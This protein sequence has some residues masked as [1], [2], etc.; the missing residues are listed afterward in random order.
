MLTRGGVL[1]AVLGG[2]N[3]AVDVTTV[4]N[5]SWMILY[6][7]A[8][9]A[10][11]TVV[12]APAGWTP[13]LASALQQTSG[14]RSAAYFAKIKEASDGVV[15]I[16]TTVAAAKRAVVIWGSGSKPVS[17]WNMGLVGVRNATH[18]VSGQ[19]IQAGTGFTSVAPAVAIDEADSLA[20]AILMEATA[21]DSSFALTSGG[22]LW[23]TW[24]DESAYIEQVL[25]AYRE[26]ATPGPGE[27]FVATSDQVQASN[28]QAMQVVIP[29]ETD[30][31]PELPGLPVETVAGPAR[32]TYLNALGERVTPERVRLLRPGFESVD[33]MLATPGATWA[34]R[35]GSLGYAE[36]SE[37]AYDQS[38]IRGY[39][40]LEFSAQR[41]SDGWW[42]GLHDPTLA[43]TSENVA[44][45]AAVNTMT[46]AQVESYFN[47]LNA[48][49]TPRPYFD[50]IEFLDKWSPSRVLILD[51]K[52]ALA[53]NT[54]FLDILD[55]HGGPE[56]IV[57]K[58]WGPSSTAIPHAVAARNRGYE[59]WGYFYEVDRSIA[60]GGNGQLD[61][62]Q[63]HWTILGMTYSSP[64]ATWDE[65]LAFDKPTVAHIAPDQSAY[66]L[67][68]SKGADMVQ[69]SG[70]NAI[71]PVGP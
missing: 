47:T 62:F 58:W 19:S 45:T 50:M 64:Q 33:Q 23:T 8:S 31:E 59:T 46:R 67:A 17:E 51:P 15:T 10:S 60:L 44:L 71:T 3:V 69:C 5:G 57:W 18:A 13:L 32:L 49:S 35:G 37:F 11:A 4:P 30:P 28:G 63:E 20:V 6:M 12:A 25:I 68:I 41:T 22:T 55:D 34:H 29:P 39:G 70:T 40:A 2:T 56:K 16:N 61:L 14:T 36:M 52:N 1:T 54:E 48:G 9:S 7:A 53:H 43:R 27:T 21:T 26:V 65:L 66:N 24:P 42:F 38:S